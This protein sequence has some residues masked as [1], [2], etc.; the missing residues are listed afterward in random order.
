MWIRLD[1]DLGGST[2][3]DVVLRSAETHR[4]VGLG[5]GAVE[6]E[7]QRCVLVEKCKEPLG[8]EGRD[9][10]LVLEAPVQTED[11]VQVQSQTAAVVHQHPQLLPLEEQHTGVRLLPWRRTA[12]HK[13]D[14]I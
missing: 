13:H 8:P 9:E 5:P 1:R 7:L 2:V 11:S 4:D 3:H 12:G 14:C 6:G 10:V